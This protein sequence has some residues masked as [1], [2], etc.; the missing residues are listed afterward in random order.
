M[1][2]LIFKNTSDKA[3][4]PG[5]E[6]LLIPLPEGF[7]GS[8][9]IEG[10]APLDLRAGQGAAV[11][12]PIS[13]N[14]GAM[15]A[16]RVRVGFVIPAG[17]LSRVELRQKMPFGLE[18]ALLLI[19]ANTNLTVEGSGL[20]ERPAQA[21]AQGN[22][23][24]LYE[25]D[26]IPPGGNLALTVKG[27]PALDHRG[28]NIAGVL[29]LLLIVAAVIGSPRPP[30][31][32]RAVASAAQLAERREKLFSELVSLEQQR[33]QARSD[34]KRDEAVE[35]RRQELVIKLENV[36]RELAGVE[37]GTRAAS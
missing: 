13:P 37:H 17:G 16:T 2:E 22:S 5:P 32:T 34:G 21:D 24:K 31:V 12:A 26:A 35:E 15:F 25:L 7:E 8:K 10:S 18:G 9:E 4:D 27:L 29:C 14:T 23:V 36:Y 1:E 30:K 28:R 3:F 19:P 11:H 20:H 6:G 33:R